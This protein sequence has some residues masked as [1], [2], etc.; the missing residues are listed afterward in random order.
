MVQLM[1]QRLMELD[2]D[3]R[4]GAGCDEKNPAERVN[5]RNGHASAP[6]TRA[7]AASS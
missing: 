4:C 1:A 2:V 6:G 5:S 3:G 7:R